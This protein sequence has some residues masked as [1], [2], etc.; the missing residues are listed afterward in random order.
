MGNNCCGG[1]H[2]DDPFGHLKHLSNQYGTI[3]SDFNLPTKNSTMTETGRDHKVSFYGVEVAPR[4]TMKNRKGYKRAK[5]Y[6]EPELSTSEIGSDM[7]S[8]S[9]TNQKIHTGKFNLS[10]CF[11]QILFC[12]RST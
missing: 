7:E 2:S 5:S 10:L 1:D 9:P 3:Q 6:V 8:S 11:I 4:H 12:K